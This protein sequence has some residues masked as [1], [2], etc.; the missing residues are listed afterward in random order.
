MKSPRGVAAATIEEGL[1][2]ARKIGYPVMARVAYALGG[3]GSGHLPERD[4]AHG[5]P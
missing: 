2:V 4:R 1:S 3:R 5:A